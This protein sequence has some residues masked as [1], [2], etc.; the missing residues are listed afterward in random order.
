MK[1]YGLLIILPIATLTG[2]SRWERPGANDVARQADYAACEARGFD[3]FPPDVVRD[4]EFDYG[5]KY[6]TCEKNKKT[7][8]NGYRYEP[9]P[10]LRTVQSDRNQDARTATIAACMYGKGWHEKTYYWP[11]W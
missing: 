5:D 6:V 10:S 2:C 11:Q 3:R 8:P 7:C 9:R 4:I 1:T